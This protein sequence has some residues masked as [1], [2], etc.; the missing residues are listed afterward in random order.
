MLFTLFRPFDAGKWVVWGLL[1]FLGGN[2]QSGGTPNFNSQFR[3]RGGLGGG[4]GEDLRHFV[5]WVQGNLSWLIPL[6]VGILL[7]GLVL[8]L[9]LTWVCARGRFM[10]LECLAYDSRRLAGC[11]SRSRLPARSLLGWLIPVQL[12]S[13][14][15][16]LAMI[17]GI[18]W[19]LNKGTDQILLSPQ[20]YVYLAGLFLFLLV[21]GLIGVLLEDFVVP[22]MWAH[23]KGVLA[24]WHYLFQLIQARP[25]TFLRYVL[26]RLVIT[27]SAGLAVLA[28]T[29]MTCCC[30]S[31]PVLGHILL[32]PVHV[33]MRMYPIFFLS[34]MDAPWPPCSGGGQE[35]VRLLSGVK[36]VRAGWGIV[37]FVPR[38]CG[39]ACGKKGKDEGL[40]IGPGKTS[41][42]LNP[43]VR[44]LSC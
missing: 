36:R 3:G 39:K 42:G 33:L 23:G 43:G 22:V 31:L 29:C 5:S 24:G 37:E 25:G 40:E 13:G 8:W 20:F 7:L 27:F 12:T 34:Q 11:W 41:I 21:L 44:C 28:G 9:L 2:L 35:G 17:A 6:M 30:A 14:I 26:F 4:S 19:L 15:L 32:L 18:L 1:A 38:P 16:I 10:Y